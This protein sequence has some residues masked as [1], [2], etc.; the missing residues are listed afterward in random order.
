MFKCVLLVSVILFTGCA[1]SP[2]D[3]EQQR[4]Q[5]HSDHLQQNGI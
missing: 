4:Q 3:Y 1:T 5:E 2:E